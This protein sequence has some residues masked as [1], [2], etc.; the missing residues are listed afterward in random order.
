MAGASTNFLTKCGL[1]DPRTDVSV[2]TMT[3]RRSLCVKL[4]PPRNKK[5]SWTISF[6]LN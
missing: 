5:R 4:W 3:V 2:P 1:G 6:R